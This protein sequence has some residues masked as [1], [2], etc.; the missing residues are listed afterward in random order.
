MRFSSYNI[1]SGK[2][3]GEGY[4]LLHGLT[5]EID[6][7]SDELYEYIKTHETFEADELPEEMYKV[8]VEH[9]FITDKTPEQELA[10]AA[11]YVRYLERENRT[12]S[13][14]IAPNL[15]CNYRCVY[16]FERD[17]AY[18]N[19]RACNVMSKEDVDAVFLFMSRNSTSKS[20]TLFGGEPLCKDNLEI[21]DYIISK[22]EGNYSF[23]AIT[24]GHDLDCFLPYFGAGKISQVQITI[25]GPKHIHDKRRIPLDKSSSFDKIIANIKKIAHNEELEI[26]I[27]INV[28]RTNLPHL[29]ELMDVFR[30]EGLID[31]ENIYIHTRLV[32]G[33]GMTEEDELG[34][35]KT[36]DDLN[37]KVPQCI[38]RPERYKLRQ[39]V[40]N[41]LN[42]RDPLPRRANHCGGT[43]RMLVFAPD[44]LVYSCWD[45]VGKPHRAIARYDMNGNVE[46]N[47]DKYAFLRKFWLENNPTCI[48]C[49]LM[50]FCRGGCF[51]EAL[52]AGLN[53][54]PRVCRFYKNEFVHILEQTVEGWL[55]AKKN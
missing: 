27:R 10:F 13:I 22:A 23:S 35:E 30:S 21:I 42:N 9:G 47:E 3:P 41:S 1:L 34:I 28:D 14:V 52:E 25:D 39:T 17:S 15:D 31:K 16:C 19:H 51:K 45:Y 48:E 32:S 40:L 4:I 5:G 12:Y 26:E 50:L 44:N 29:E 54:D 6:L 53:Y 55:S 24:N 49:P 18:F 36:L 7:I 38:V 37:A 20:I 33:T 11:S 8:Y 46:W 43:G 2:L